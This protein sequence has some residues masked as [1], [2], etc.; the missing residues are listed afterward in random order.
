MQSAENIPAEGIPEQEKL[1]RFIGKIML[2]DLMLILHKLEKEYGFTKRIPK[3][4]LYESWSYFR[5]R[6]ERSEKIMGEMI[7]AGIIEIC[8]GPNGGQ[9][10]VSLRGVEEAH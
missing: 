4:E 9:A 10:Y 8:G 2:P 7:R 5:F 3:A 1:E 6:R